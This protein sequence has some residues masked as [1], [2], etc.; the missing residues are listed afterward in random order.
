M[1]KMM[2]GIL[3]HTIVDFNALNGC[4]TTVTY[5]VELRDDVKSETLIWKVM[6]T[7]EEKKQ[8]NNVVDLLKRDAHFFL[9]LHIKG[10]SSYVNAALKVV[11]DVWRRKQ[12]WWMMKHKCTA[13]CIALRC[14]VICCPVKIMMTT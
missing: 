4:E 6:H 14:M 10:Q 9:Y 1:Q 3:W 7:F 12:W 5:D 2:I 8:E 13:L 11:Y